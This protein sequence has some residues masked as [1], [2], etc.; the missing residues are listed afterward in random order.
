MNLELNKTYYC[1]NGLT[2]TLD[3]KDP[4]GLSGEFYPG[5]SYTYGDMG[6]ENCLKVFPIGPE[7]PWDIISE[8]NH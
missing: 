5:F 2:I 1:R 8:A 4:E 7:S 6:T 3:K